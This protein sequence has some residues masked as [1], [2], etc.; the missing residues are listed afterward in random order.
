MPDESLAP[1]NVIER[2]LLDF[3]RRGGLQ[4]KD[5]S[6]AAI[7]VEESLLLLCKIDLKEIANV[8]S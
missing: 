2:C 7:R 4:E 1:I 8:R 5:V 3:V 6:E